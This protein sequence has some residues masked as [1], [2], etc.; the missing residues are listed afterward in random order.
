MHYVEGIDRTQ[1]TMFSLEEAVA[2]DSLARIIDVFVDSLDLE[3]LGYTHA[4]LGPEGRPPYSPNTMLKLYMYGYQHGLRSTRKL[5]HAAAVNI[6]LIWLLEGRKPSNRAIARFRKQNTKAFRNTMTHFVKML[7]QWGLIEGKTIAI[8]SFKIRAQN[9][10]KNNFNQAKIDR[11]LKYINEKIDAY[12][13][14][15]DAQECPQKIEQL[16]EKMYRQVQNHE[17]YEDIQAQLEQSAESQISLTDPDARAVVLHRNIVNVGYNIQAACDEKHKLFISADCLGV[18][19]TH[20]LHPMAKGVM[21]L[22]D[23]SS[24]TT[25]SDKGYTTG[26][27]LDKCAN[28][29]ITTYSS[30]KDSASNHN[31]LFNVEAFT[32]NPK[33]DTY[34]CPANQPLT[35]NGTSY[36]KGNYTVKHYKTKA[37]KNCPLRSQCTNSKNGRF[38]ERSQHQHIIEQNRNRVNANPDYYRQR[39]QITEHQFGTLKRQWGFTFALMKGKQAVLAEAELFM[40]I[41]NPSTSSG[42][43]FV[44]VCPYLA[45]MPSTARSKRWFDSF[46]K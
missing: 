31:N 40:I 34:T 21:D 25:L 18:N 16:N 42:Q 22:L 14:E 43:A 17:R 13:C 3:Q 8:D 38:I 39:Q 11:Q 12:I 20:A 27:Q 9:A 46:F 4:N 1:M 28:D 26:E 37:C 33:S 35:T 24:L 19:D 6:E 5:E 15:M 2:K 36:N 10:L 45:Q 29:N 23:L 32:Y 30:P 41:Y 7:H 44:E